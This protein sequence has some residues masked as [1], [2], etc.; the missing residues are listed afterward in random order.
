VSLHDEQ[1][2]LTVDPVA[3]GRTPEQSALAAELNAAFANALA[4]LTAEEA[5]I[6]RLR[7]VQGCSLATIRR[8]LHLERLTEERVTT[9]LG[10]IRAALEG[11]GAGAGNAGSDHL[12]FLSS[13]EA[14]PGEPA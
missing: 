3:T 10:R 1:G 2:R 8:A 5:A 6:V 9:I 14:G 4:A 13:P 11:Q 12:T 7:F